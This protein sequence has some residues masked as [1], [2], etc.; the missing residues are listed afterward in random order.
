MALP[1]AE[2]VRRY[3]QHVPPEGFHMV[4]GYG[5]YRRGSQNNHLRDRA[6]ETV[7][8]SPELRAEI[9]PDTT[10]SRQQ[11]SAGRTL[12]A[13]CG[14]PVLHE[15]PPSLT[16]VRQTCIA[17]ASLR[18]PQRPAPLR[19]PSYRRP[20][21]PFHLEPPNASTLDVPIPH[22]P[23]PIPP[24]VI[25]IDVRAGATLGGRD[26]QQVGEADGR[27]AFGDGSPAAYLSVELNRYAVDV[28]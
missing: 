28:S 13:T 10:A 8:L 20:P 16:D 14:V 11:P 6:A 21:T 15:H 7:P 18:F 17:P 25:S 3:L 19:S 12:C 27:G 1:T 24:G 5:L 22:L 4:R 2:F 26:V 23:R 9:A